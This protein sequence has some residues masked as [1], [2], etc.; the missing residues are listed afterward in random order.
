MAIDTYKQRQLH[1]R[2]DAA[3]HG[4]RFTL[5]QLLSAIPAAV[6]YFFDWLF[7]LENLLFKKVKSHMAGPFG[8]LLGI[9]PTIV[10]LV[11]GEVLQQLLNIPMYIGFVIDKG[12]NLLVSLIAFGKDAHFDKAMSGQH[13]GIFGAILGLIY[14][15]FTYLTQIPP[16]LMHG[17]F[18]FFLGWIPQTIRFVFT[19]IAE[20]F[21]C[22]PQ[23]GMDMLCDSISPAVSKPENTAHDEPKI[24]VE[25]K[26]SAP[27]K[28]KY[29][30]PLEV[31]A[32]ENPD[33]R[34]MEDK[35]VD[36]FALLGI[37]SQRF[38]H[39][40]ECANAAYKTLA[41][42]Y[43]PDSIKDNQ[44]DSEQFA[45]IN[46]AIKILRDADMSKHYLNWYKKNMQ[47]NSSAAFF[48]TPQSSAS[49]SKKPG[50]TFTR[51]GQG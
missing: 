20:L 12:I 51:P 33:L 34:E 25:E 2:E 10:G 13:L 28:G 17:P 4:L 39:D 7:G 26:N 45:K 46:K 16:Q 38:E 40:P 37:D 8:F 48:Q 5:S 30:R 21:I 29:Q 1:F 18:A 14:G 42:K 41:R 49:Q 24:S 32:T 19:R 27:K 47:G 11:V 50:R 6:G 3:E 36:L 44:A 43:H 22:I 15:A 31:L 23:H 9:I 35:K